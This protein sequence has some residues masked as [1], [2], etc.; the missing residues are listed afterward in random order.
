MARLTTFDIVRGVYVIKPDA[1]QGEHI[2]KLGKLED[3]DEANRMEYTTID[4]EYEYECGH[5]SSIVLSRDNF[6]SCCGQRLREA[7]E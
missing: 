6:C 2:Q 3:R 1:P 5:C 7:V 4:N